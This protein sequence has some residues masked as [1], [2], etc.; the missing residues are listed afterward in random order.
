MADILITRLP[1]GRDRARGRRA[2]RNFGNRHV[3]FGPFRSLY[4]PQDYPARVGETIWQLEHCTSLRPRRLRLMRHS[5]SQRRC[6]LGREVH[7]QISSWRASYISSPASRQ[8]SCFD[9]MQT[10]SAGFL[11]SRARS[12]H[13]LSFFLP[14]L[15]RY[16]Q[17]H[18]RLS[19]DP[20]ATLLRRFLTAGRTVRAFLIRDA[21]AQS[22][23]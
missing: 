10:P 21:S 7:S 19:S 23:H 2:P 17:Q 3:R 18:F 20:L 14:L 11:L 22:V 16:R 15:A 12:R 1:Y 8:N 4:L 5:W 6:K 13:R 9:R